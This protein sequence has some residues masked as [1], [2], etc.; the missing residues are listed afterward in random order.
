MLEAEQ[1]LNRI[2]SLLNKTRDDSVLCGGIPRITSCSQGEVILFPGDSLT[3]NCSAEKEEK[4]TYSW[5][6]NNELIRKSVDGTF[7][8]G[9]VTKNSEG[10]YVCVVANNKGSKLSNV[11]IVKVHGKPKITQHPQ[12]Q[13]EVFKS[14]LPAIFICNAT[15]E[16]TPTFQWFFQPADSPAIKINQTKPVL[17]IANPLP[18]QEGYYYYRVASNEHGS[19]VSQRAR[20]DVLRYTIGLPRLLIPFNLTTQCWLASNSSKSSTQDPPPCDLEPIDIL[21]SSLDQ[22]L[23]NDL[24]RA[25]ARSLNVT[26]E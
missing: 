21:P 1:A 23:T 7:Y 6:R 24:L 12:V 26:V 5:K 9:E 15:A 25:L 16:P 18:H 22:N 10:A 4:L 17:Y 20:L 14:Q 13:R 3:L 2:A 8:V 19:A 11:T